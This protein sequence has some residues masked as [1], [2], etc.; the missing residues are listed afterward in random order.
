MFFVLIPLLVDDPLWAEINSDNITKIKVLIP[1]LV[2]D[3]LWE[4]LDW[5]SIPLPWSLNPSFSGW[6]SLG[7]KMLLLALCLL[8]CLNPSFSGWPSLGCKNCG[9]N[10]NAYGVLIPLLVDDPLWETNWYHWLVMVVGLNPS[11]SGWP[12]LGIRSSGQFHGLHVLIPLLV[13]DPLWAPQLSSLF[14][15]LQS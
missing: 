6:P 2:D 3:P 10:D 15:Y 13:D 5:V 4:T 9:N 1:L 12:S 7:S 8:R 14:L 11:F